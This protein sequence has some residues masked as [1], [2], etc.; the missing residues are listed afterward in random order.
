MDLLLKDRRNYLF[1]NYT[2]S[3]WSHVVKWEPLDLDGVLGAEMEYSF[4]VYDCFIVVQKKNYR[5]G[6]WDVIIQM[7]NTGKGNV[8]DWEEANEVNCLCC[9]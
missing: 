1:W 9:L 8:P 5:K 3:L 6:N 4:L 2:A 7:V